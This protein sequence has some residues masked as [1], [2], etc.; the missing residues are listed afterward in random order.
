MNQVKQLGIWMDHSKAFLMDL[1]DNTIVEKSV[2]SE[3]TPYEKE[4]TLEKSERMMHN[5]EQQDQASYYKKIGDM[6]RS[7]QEVILF[8]PTDAKLELLNLLKADHLFENIKIEVLNADK[9]TANQMHDFVKEHF[10]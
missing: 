10:K 6:I 3:F 8:G 7:Y 4:F 1:T 9:M 5:K 2:T